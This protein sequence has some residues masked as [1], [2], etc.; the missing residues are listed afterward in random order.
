MQLFCECEWTHCGIKTECVLWP[1]H[2]STSFSFERA[3]SAQSPNLKISTRPPPPPPSPPPALRAGPVWAAGRPG[4]ARIRTVAF[5]NLFGLDNL[6]SRSFAKFPNV[7]QQQSSRVVELSCFCLMQT[8][9]EIFRK[10][11]EILS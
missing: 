10:K 2:S 5:Q 6:T 9:R 4:P 7:N 11:H 8:G 1:H 3:T